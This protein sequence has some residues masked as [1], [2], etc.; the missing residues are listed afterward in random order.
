M[1]ERTVAGTQRGLTGDT[2]LEGS[3]RGTLSTM[4]TLARMLCIPSF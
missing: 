4:S 2:P 3:V 1:R